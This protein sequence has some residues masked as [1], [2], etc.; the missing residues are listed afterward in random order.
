MDKRPYIIGAVGAS[1]TVVLGVGL[2][3]RYSG[4]SGSLSYANATKRI[5]NC[6]VL[7]VSSTERDGV[8]LHMKD[9]RLHGVDNTT[10][11]EK[12]ESEFNS[13]IKSTS[14]KCGSQTEYGIE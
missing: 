1:A 2:W 6:E 5:A 12:G 3:V 10:W 9:G 8:I 7:S 4:I 13:A 11:S 14:A